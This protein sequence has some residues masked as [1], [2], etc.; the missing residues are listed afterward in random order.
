MAMAM[1]LSKVMIG[2]QDLPVTNTIYPIIN[3]V[4][5]QRGGQWGQWSSE[6][7]S[8][9]ELTDP[10][11]DNGLGPNWADS[12]ETHKAAWTTTISATGTIDN[13]D[14]AADEL[15]LLLEGVGEV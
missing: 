6:G 2:G 9:L 4:T 7:G 8:S 12:D 14:V 3:E 11:S 10:R 1:P 5:Y 15:Q 13:G